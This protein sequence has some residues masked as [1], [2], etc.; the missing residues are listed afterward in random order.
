M[1]PPDIFIILG[2]I[3]GAVL[4]GVIFWKLMDVIKA[5]INRNNNSFNEESFDRMAKAFI[6]H[7]KNTERRLKNLETIVTDNEPA[8]DRQLDQP[9]STETIEIDDASQP[10]EHGES[11]KSGLNNMLNKE[12]GQ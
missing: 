9:R 7:K 6:Q 3:F 10:R 12:R 4:T 5:W 8:T 1:T 2:I 11:S